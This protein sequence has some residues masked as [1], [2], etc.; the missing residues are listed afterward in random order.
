MK[1]EPET[2]IMKKP[3]QKKIRLIGY[4]LYALVLT[5]LFLYL[6]FPS[7]SLASYLKSA[8]GRANPR[9]ILSIGALAPELPPGI[10]ISKAEIAFKKTPLKPIVNLHNLSLKPDPWAFIQGTRACCFEGR[11]YGGEISG[12][13]RFEE[14]GSET[15]FTTSIRLKDLHMGRHAYLP[16]LMGRSFSG[17]LAGEIHY[18]G[19]NARLIQGDG[20]ATIT[21]SRGVAGLPRPVMGLESI[22][23]DR[24]FIKMTL[25]NGKI[26]VSSA[27][28]EGRTLKGRLSGTVTLKNKI[29][30]SRLDLKGV[31]EPQTGLLGKLSKN[32]DSIRLLRKGLKNLK[33]SFIIRGTFEAPEFR[34]M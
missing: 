32:P 4:L 3:P 1:V 14:R 28:L 18:S 7:E 27:V 30:T 17:T 10:E 23:F 5:A 6:R 16:L 19:D 25:K 24:L 11:A 15:C 26:T 13:L 22:P 29:R 33:Q 31:V 9:L 20:A 12:N 21:I 2:G 8:L 34:F